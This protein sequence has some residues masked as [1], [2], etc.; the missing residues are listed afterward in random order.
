MAGAF[1]TSSIPFH[2]V[3][4]TAE[5]VQEWHLQKALLK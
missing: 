5:I 1:L 2:K 3:C 4:V